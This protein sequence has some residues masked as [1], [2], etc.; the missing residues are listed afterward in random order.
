MNEKKLRGWGERLQIARGRLSQ[1]KFISELGEGWN[2][3]SLSNYEN[4]LSPIDIERLIRL[5]EVTGCSIDWIA[6]GDGTHRPIEDVPDYV[7]RQLVKEL[8]E[9]DVMFEG[10]DSETKYRM[11]VDFVLSRARY[12]TMRQKNKDQRQARD[13]RQSIIEGNEI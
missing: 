13:K 8:I 2:R 12:L 11:I 10:Q 6:V 9:G 7:V 3:R 5:R 4:E 1:D